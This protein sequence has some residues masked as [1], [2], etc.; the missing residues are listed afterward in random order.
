MII[1]AVAQ[2]KL[3]RVAALRKPRSATTTAAAAARVP[4]TAPAFKAMENS[5]EELRS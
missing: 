3:V 5:S 1:A 4:R 2:R